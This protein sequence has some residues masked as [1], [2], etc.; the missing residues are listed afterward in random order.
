LEEFIK[1]QTKL[2]LEGYPVDQSGG[3]V[4]GIQYSTIAD[5][6]HMKKEVVLTEEQKLLAGLDPTSFVFSE[7]VRPDRGFSGETSHITSKVVE[8]WINQTLSDAEHLDI[9][10]VILKPENK[11]PITRYGIDRITLT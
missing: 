8:N 9:P 11:V 10:S 5:G 4:L 2:R 1:T 6:S 3:E 7:D